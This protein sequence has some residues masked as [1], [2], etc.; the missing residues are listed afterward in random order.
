MARVVSK[1]FLLPYN[2]S[3]LRKLRVNRDK[4]LAIS[5]REFEVA[6]QKNEINSFQKNTPHP[7]E[8][9]YFVSNPEQEA[10]WMKHERSF[11]WNLA[12]ADCG[13]ILITC[14]MQS[15]LYEVSTVVRKANRKCIETTYSC[16]LETA[17]GSVW[18]LFCVG[19]RPSSTFQ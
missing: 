2:S 15:M 4:W 19:K 17:Y 14:W 12:Q 18:I 10:L 6:E 8:E 11:G 5:G 13:H 1:V 16:W 7:G 3:T 9:F